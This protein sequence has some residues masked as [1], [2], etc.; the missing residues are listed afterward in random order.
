MKERK[1]KPEKRAAILKAA[2]MVFAQKGFYNSKVTDIAKQAGVADGT[3]YIYFKNKDDLLISLFEDRMVDILKRFNHELS[4]IEHASDKLKSF[5]K[6]YFEMIQEDPLLAEVFQV[7]LRQSDKFLKN[8]HNQNFL[9]YLNIIGSILHQG[10]EDGIFR[11]DLNV[12]IM[13]IM[14]FGSIDEVARQWILGADTKYSLNEAA[15]QVTKTILHGIENK[16]QG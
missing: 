7:E 11:S 9:D 2:V 14:I 6:V 13:K 5:F 16:N 15:G 10:V 3:I 1:L 8:Y 4:G 12:G